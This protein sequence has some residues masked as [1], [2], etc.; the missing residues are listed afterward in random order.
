[1]VGFGL[2][3]VPTKH[4]ALG[5]I[6]TKYQ[7]GDPSARKYTRARASWDC[8][9]KQARIWGCLPATMHP[10]GLMVDGHAVRV[11]GGRQRGKRDGD[12][13]ALHSALYRLSAASRGA[14]TKGQ[15]RRARTI[16]Q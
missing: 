9:E 13:D 12:Q 11:R 10:T 5:A 2:G 1:M 4:G 6:G 15:G 7:Y 3:R 8:G 16:T 14:K